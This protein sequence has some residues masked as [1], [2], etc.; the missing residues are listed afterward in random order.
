[1]F[2]GVTLPTDGTPIAAQPARNARYR[3]ATLEEAKA[4]V[5]SYAKAHPTMTFTGYVIDET[6]HRIIC[7]TIYYPKP[8]VEWISKDVQELEALY[9]KERLQ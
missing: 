6:T 1:M 8:V 4:M 2:I 7:Y 3:C 5:E 9:N